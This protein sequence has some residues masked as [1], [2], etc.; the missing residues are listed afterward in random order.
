MAQRLRVFIS[1]PGDVPD[2]RLRADLVVD[3]LNQEYARY[4]EL[5]TH[6]WEHEPMLASGHF[7]DA[8]DPPS[9]F[10]IVILILWSRLGTPLPDHTATRDYRGIDGRAPVTGTEWEFEDALRAAQE[11]GAPDILAFRNLSPAPVDTADLEAQARSLAQ[12]TALNHFWTRHFA[13]RGV[14][15]AA[16][17]SYRTLEEFAQKLEQSLRKLIER[18]IRTMD[19]TEQ[20]QSAAIWLGS[21]FRGLEA[22]EFEHAAI[23]FGRDAA[24]GRAI[25]QLAQHARAGC[26][27]LLVSGASGSGKSSLVKAALLPR[28]M[29]PQRIQG[30]AFVRR[31]VLR[32][33][34]AQGGDLVL[35]LI[36]ALLRG[37]EGL[38][39]PELLGPGQ[40][41]GELAQHLRT[42]PD[43]AGF[44]FSGALGRVTD[45]A[46][47]TGRL[48]AHEDAKLILVI[49]QL[50]ELFTL[51]AITTDERRLFIGL[52][53]RLARAD[54]VW[55]V[56][57]VRAD[58]W[59]RVAELPELVALCEGQGR[60]DVSA[61]SA[62]E[63]SEI[64]RRPAQAAGLAFEEHAERGVRLDALL[65]EHAAAAPGVLP[66]LSFTLEALYAEDVVKRGG[67]LLTHA[68]YQA[69]GGL[70][71][72]IA[73]R[74]DETVA[75]LPAEAQAALPRVLRTLTTLGSGA[76]QA[77]MARAASLDEF[78]AGGAARTLVEALTAA[79]L[80]VAASDGAIATV[81][82]AHEALLRRW[83]R[84]RDQLE[85]DRRDLETRVL[86]ERQERRW[87]AATGTAQRQL[88]LRDPDLA[89]AL[90][91]VRRWAD[92]LPAALRDFIAKSSSAARAA[93]RRRW[94][95][96]AGVMT[97]L[98]LLAAASFGA[99]YIA[100]IQRNE[101]LVAQSRFL[102]R[103]GRSATEAGAATRGLLL[104]LAG[105]PRV[106]ADPDR[107]L[108]EPAEYALEDAMAN[109]RERVIL[110]GHGATL[111]G[112]AFSPDGTRLVT[113]AEDGTAHLW[114]VA[115][116][117][118]IGVLRG[119]AGRIW[120]A[121]FAPDGTR[122]ATASEDDSARVWDV[123]TGQP[124]AVLRGH[125]DGV[126]SVAFSPDGRHV[127]TGSDDKTAR[128][129]DAATGAPIAVLT[130][131]GLVN[132]VAFSPDG[133]RLLTAS[134]DDTAR[135]WDA[136]TG[137]PV[138]VLKGHAGFV[139]AAAFSADG[140]RIVTASWD[141]TARL[142]DAATGAPQAVLR[143]HDGWVI[144]ASF[145]PDGTRV[146][147]ASTDDTARLWDAAT[148]S[149]IAILLGHEG[150]LTGA[151]FSPDGQRVITASEDRTVRLWDA[152]SGRVV[153]T[154]RGH[155]GLVEAALF[156]PDGREIASLSTDGTARLWTTETADAAGVLRGHEDWINAVAI[157][158]DGKLVATA[159]NDHTV[160]LWEIATGKPVAVLRGHEDFVRALAFTRGGKRLI[161]GADDRTARVWDVATGKPLAVLQA[162]AR[163]WAVAVSPDGTRVATGAEDATAR[164]WNLETQA[165]TAVLRGHQA[166]VSAVAFSPDGTRVA[167]AS[168][169][170]TVRLWDA[171]S[172]APLAE[173][174]GHDGRV[175]ALAFS[176]DGS[177]LAT[178]SDDKTA[179][180]WDLASGRTVAV[181]RG[182][183]NWIY[184]V[185]FSPDG[186]RV[187]TASGDDTARLW[188]AETGAPILTL[189]GHGD[190]V[191][192]ADFTPD[193]ASVVTG[194][195]DRTARLWRLPPR[196][197][198]LI[199][200]AERIAPRHPSAAEREQFFLEGRP[201]A[202]GAMSW[203]ARWFAP[204]LPKAGDTCG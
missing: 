197:Q 64:I 163:V 62:A 79:R 69:L 12:L 203:L 173:L 53:A 20:V 149:P 140:R 107:P 193:G 157:A 57:T 128:L 48:L 73:T 138:A 44:L 85:A 126:V 187:L 145:S 113:A 136:T 75:R 61:P 171:N 22:Y 189:R 104:A 91:L 110:D 114:N 160:R 10:D 86:I 11:R 181:M 92:E 16:Y 95:I 76:D 155:V 8:I 168:W 134:T 164:L 14:F 33:S 204:L 162:G 183:D 154:L 82:L 169:D 170:K 177:R 200:E 9:Q 93:M 125:T 116:G 31:L 192:A 43:A 159:S 35:G 28:L 196:C 71:G 152:R 66:L 105:L 4:F 83:D 7:Q 5:A 165:E 100:E 60:L 135:L 21:P 87:R 34:D 39:L 80:L 40:R 94:A 25:E 70:E 123:A 172:G 38:G 153:G 72:A 186:R 180:V 29:K 118:E 122:V 89:N 199:D 17:D 101:A 108:I 78:P 58:F 111:W 115:A 184:A 24:V 139:Q 191:R 166:L 190:A 144:A 55:I 77:T 49:D 1:S 52:L 13:D 47:K 119:H 2:E 167:T 106:L 27:F 98:A 185:R 124:V 3:K 56:A 19:A 147:T 26:A 18:R 182:H 84:A 36:E 188:D 156:S 137:A 117:T 175:P 96:A 112:G 121:V 174:K 176:P 131:D 143:G 15:L 142:W 23:F 88:L 150:R 63:L 42:A 195:A 141:K 202:A 6:R 120:T 102:A 59:H 54:C 74:A 68:T 41:A 146:V 148:G 99:F 129:W 97:G 133:R 50:E 90:D 151:A 178:A 30:A 81:R 194:S 65:A 161:S 130:H 67:R 109:R 127:A 179:R 51:P 103:D 46:R 158:P 32:P 132:Q 198:P 201:T 45:A 37:G